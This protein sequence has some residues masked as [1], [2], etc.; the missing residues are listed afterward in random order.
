MQYSRWRLLP[1]E[2]QQFCDARAW[3]GLR[4]SD[5]CD[6]HIEQ[7]RAPAADGPGHPG[8]IALIRLEPDG[9]L[10]G[11]LVAQLC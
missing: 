2:S 9:G 8:P 1:N 4:Q 7:C 6:L 10:V 5:G 11:R 3:E